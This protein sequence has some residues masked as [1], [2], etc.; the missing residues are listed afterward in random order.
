MAD[1]VPTATAERLGQLLGLSAESV[2]DLYRRGIVVRRSPGKYELA[3][4]IAAYC[5]HLREVA[6]GRGGQD[7]VVALASERARLA[8]EQADAHALRNA[9]LRGELVALSDAE[10]E[11]ATTLRGVRSAMLAVPSRVR[12]RLGNLSAAEAA[13]IEDEV[14]RALTEACGV[15]SGRQ[16]GPLRDCR[17]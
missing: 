13:V 11:W 7:E 8:R 3:A 1:K 15:G 10:R 14:R 2:R 12:Q 6:S 17:F 16:S 5:R 4:S 9:Q